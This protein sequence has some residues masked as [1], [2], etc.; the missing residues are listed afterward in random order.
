[1]PDPEPEVEEIEEVDRVE[2][3]EPVQAADEPRRL[4]RRKK[5]RKDR[6][7]SAVPIVLIVLGA[8]AAV[9]VLLV[10]LAFFSKS[11]WIGF[12]VVG[13][14]LA[15]VGRLWFMFIARQ[16]DYVTYLMVRFVPFYSIYYFL[17]RIH[18]TYKPFLIGSVGS[19]FV[20]TGLIAMGVRGVMKH[21]EEAAKPEPR[22]DVRALAP[23]EREKLAQKLLERTDKAEARAWLA[24][25]PD[26]YMLDLEHD[27][28]VRHVQALYARGAKEVLVAFIETTEEDEESAVYL[29]IGLPE[30]D[31]Q[32]LFEYVRSTFNAD[33]KDTGQKYLVVR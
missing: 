21:H 12:L 25:R 24:N 8:S 30:N 27:E 14:P 3:V 7:R 33:D 9:F 6:N 5:K 32:A 26:R 19:V 31:R 28:S 10:V 4:K 20:V 16:E 17:T 13:I 18:E 11:G 1:V 15:L 23:A 22:Q 29:V 2:E